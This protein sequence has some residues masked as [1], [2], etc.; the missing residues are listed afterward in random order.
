M[1][2]RLVHHFFFSR[3]DIIY[4]YIGNVLVSVNPFKNIEGLYSERKLKDC[5]FGRTLLAYFSALN[6]C[7]QIRE[8]TCT[9]CRPTY[10]RLPI[11][12]TASS[13]KRASRNVSSFLENLAPAKRKLRKR[14]AR[15]TLISSWFLSHLLCATPDF[16]VHCRRVV[17]QSGCESCQ[18]RH[19]RIQSAARIV[20]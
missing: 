8:S 10:L 7:V 11:K 4:T 2:C 16:T 19:Y 13:C 9:S 18:E 5:K 1:L 3:Q 12:S 14:Y 20:W 17:Q 15:G 6:C